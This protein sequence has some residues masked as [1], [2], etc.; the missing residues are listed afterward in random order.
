MLLD[1]I[2]GNTDAIISVNPTGFSKE[3][4]SEGF[5]VVNH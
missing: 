5:A 4:M 3:S 2:W 1:T